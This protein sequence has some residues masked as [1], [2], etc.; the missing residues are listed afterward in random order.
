MGIILASFSQHQSCDS[1]VTI[2]EE[3]YELDLGPQTTFYIAKVLCHTHFFPTFEKISTA[4]CISHDLL[5][6]SASP[7]VMRVLQLI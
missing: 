2:T 7:G 5:P 1:H 6:N 4:Y 3:K